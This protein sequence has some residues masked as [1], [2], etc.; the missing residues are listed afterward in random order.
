MLIDEACGAQGNGLIVAEEGGNGTRVLF[1]GF[2]R[3]RQRRQDL[4]RLY[5]ANPS[6]APRSS[7]VP[8][9]RNDRM[10]WRLW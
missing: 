8:Q 10:P 3:Q 4:E 2:Y 6:G 7:A 5:F 1:A 9:R